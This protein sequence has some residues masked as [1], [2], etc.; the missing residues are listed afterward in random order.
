MLQCNN[1]YVQHIEIYYDIQYGVLI[2]NLLEFVDGKSNR[3]WDGFELK[4][5]RREVF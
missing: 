4:K 1:G 3:S 2:V 5:N